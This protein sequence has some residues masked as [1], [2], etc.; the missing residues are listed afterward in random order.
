MA[1]GKAS[2]GAGSGA[3]LSPL[4]VT[5][6]GLTPGAHPG[7]TGT[8][9]GLLAEGFPSGKGRDT[10]HVWCRGRVQAGADKVGAGSPSCCNPVR[11]RGEDEDE[12]APAPSRPRGSPS[13]AAAAA[14]GL[15]RGVGGC[16]SGCGAGGL[17]ETARAMRG[18]QLPWKP[19][20]QRRREAACDA[21]GT[22]MSR[23]RG[24]D[25]GLVGWEPPHRPGPHQGPPERGVNPC[26]LRQRLRVTSPGHP[27][28][29]WMEQ[30]RGPGAGWRWTP[31]SPCPQGP[32]QP[33]TP[34]AVA[35][36]L[37]LIPGGFSSIESGLC[38]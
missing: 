17:P 20:G 10:G 12:D 7:N 18:C 11:D 31:S 3:G 14:G 23:E 38:G 34:R 13:D 4:C 27:H 9:R 26:D 33:P 36:I 8:C 24:G 22:A 30:P 19:L 15:P 28:H 1:G 25:V 16:G 37:P 2:P 32:P 5:K 21:I 29:G 6:P 35:T